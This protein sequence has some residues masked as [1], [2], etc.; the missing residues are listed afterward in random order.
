VKLEVKRLTFAYE[1]RPVLEEL[2]FSVASGEFVSLIGPSGS[3]KSTLFY[4]IGGL[5]K[6]SAGDILLDGQSIVGQRGR[7]GYMPQQPSLLPWRTAFENVLLAQELH[8]RLEPARVRELLRE[9]G[10]A[11]A[12]KR[13]PHELSGGMQQ[14]V[15][16]V[17]ALAGQHDVLL[18]DEPFGSLDALTRTR[19]QRWLLDIL[20]AEKRTILFI[21]HSIEEALLLS[22][23]I[24]VLG[25][26]PM[27]VVRE[28]TV[29]FARKERP[30]LRGADEWLRLEREIEQLLL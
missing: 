29:P 7:V 25:S 22:D 1:K 4:L 10:L 13:Y 24:L 16:F 11:E 20:E 3:G 15:A 19:M 18:L 21:T 12:E 2:S 27:R 17:R 8:G 9:A 26:G 30:A 23:R 14:R 28:I 5:L 6:P